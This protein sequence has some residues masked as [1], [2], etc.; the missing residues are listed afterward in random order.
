MFLVLFIAFLGKRSKPCATFGANC[1]LLLCGT[2]GRCKNVVLL[3]VLLRA[4]NFVIIFVL[5][6]GGG[7]VLRLCWRWGSFL[8]GVGVVGGGGK[9]WGWGGWGGWV[10]GWW[11]G[12]GG[13]FGCWGRG[14]GGEV[15]WM[16]SGRR[17][18]RQKLYNVSA[19]PLLARPNHS[20]F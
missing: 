8:V 10:V 3:F 20:L 4:Q 1:V 6:G 5:G 17:R 15:G 7:L 9:I 19:R 2:S 14:A 13:W 16:E 11:G 12:W 18:S